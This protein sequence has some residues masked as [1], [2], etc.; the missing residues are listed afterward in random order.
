MRA[1]AVAVLCAYELKEKNSNPV[2]TKAVLHIWLKT[3]LFKPVPAFGSLFI[4][5][6][7]NLILGY[8]IQLIVIYMLSQQTS[9]RKPL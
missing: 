5:F 1:V 7:L 9:K 3:R 6:R 4:L 2:K 8:S